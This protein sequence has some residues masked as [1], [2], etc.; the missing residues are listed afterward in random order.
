MNSKFGLRAAKTLAT[1][2]T[3]GSMPVAQAYEPGEWFTRF[4]VAHISPNDD[5]GDVQAFPGNSVSV[6]SS[7]GIGVSLSYMYNEQ[8]GFE[9]L[10]ALPFEHD[11][12][13]EGPTLSGLGKIATTDQLPPTLLVN[14]YPQV[15]WQGLH[16]YIGAGVNYT[17]FFDEDASS[18][19]EAAL[20]KTD[21]NLD[22][23]VGLALQ[24]G[25]DWDWKDNWFV[26]AALWY[27]QIDTTAKLNFAGGP[28]TGGNAGKTKVDVD[29]DPWVMMVGL[30]YRFK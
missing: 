19:L 7:T 17:T 28:A 3:L 11:I 20:G 26:N 13:G 23:S 6:D 5:S 2:I 8:I 25:M 21:V 29:I 27:V 15:N 12:N 14:Y 18:S 22:D 4:G 10:G 16:P 1:L 24:L 30:G 9:V